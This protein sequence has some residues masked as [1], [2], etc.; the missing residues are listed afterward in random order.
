LFLQVEGVS[1]RDK[2]VGHGG[3]FFGGEED[4]GSKEIGAMVEVGELGKDRSII[5]DRNLEHLDF[6]HIDMY[7]VN[8]SKQSLL[9]PLR[10]DN[11][12]SCLRLLTYFSVGSSLS[13]LFRRTKKE[14]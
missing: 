6:E 3:G 8:S 2:H 12:P 9:L 1:A 14:V 11:V 5:S 7:E 13:L 10:V 4:P